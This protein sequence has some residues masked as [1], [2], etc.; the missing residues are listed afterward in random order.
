[1][2]L[3]LYHD[4]NKIYA[5]FLKYDGILANR[6]FEPCIFTTTSEIF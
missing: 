1:M 2:H 5:F 3:R 4:A 6:K